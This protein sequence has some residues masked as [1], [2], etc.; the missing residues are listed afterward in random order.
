VDWADPSKTKLSPVQKIPVAPYT[1]LCGGQL[2]ACVPQ[3]GTDRRDG[4]PCHR[5]PCP[6][7]ALEKA[8]QENT[9]HIVL[10][11]CP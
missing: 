4:H 7:D 1:Y 8:N 10:S 6:P 3:A 2:T 5:D 9:L 11:I